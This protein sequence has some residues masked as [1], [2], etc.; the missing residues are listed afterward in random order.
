LDSNN[1]FP[2]ESNPF[3]LTYKEHVVNFWKHLL[4]IPSDQSPIND[5]TGEKLINGQ[6]NSNSSVFY[7]ANDRGKSER[8]CTIPSG[9]GVLIPVMVVE[10]SDKEV[11]NATEEKLHKVAKKDQDSVTSMYLKIDD[12][13]YDKNYLSK[14]R[15]HTDAFDVVFPENAIFGVTSGKSK[16]VADGYYI[17]TDVLP[18]GKHEIHYKSSLTSEGEDHLEP[19]FEQDIKYTLT[20]E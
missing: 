6:T 2:P 20:V 3:G 16:T 5:K 10:V 1:F 17:I 12:K 9:K 18:K 19:N 14:Y 15:V 13:E 11:Q 8:T 7:L 4:S